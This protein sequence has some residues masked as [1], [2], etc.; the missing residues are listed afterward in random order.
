MLIEDG[1]PALS[2]WKLG[3]VDLPYNV[4]YVCESSVQDDKHKHKGSYP[5]DLCIESVAEEC[6][7]LKQSHPCE[8]FVPDANDAKYRQ[9]CKSISAC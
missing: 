5:N 3:V 9:N 8:G 2:L 6:W 1:L 4:N 7:L